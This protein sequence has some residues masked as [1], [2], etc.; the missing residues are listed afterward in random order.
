[1]VSRVSFFFKSAVN[2][3]FIVVLFCP[4]AFAIQSE[5]AIQSEIGQSG[6]SLP[7]FVSLKSD[8]VNVR[9]GPSQHQY[10]IAW[11]YRKQGLPVEIIQEYD[12]WRRIRDS[13]G[14]LGWVNQALLSGK[15]TVMITPWKKS[16]N[17]L[18]TMRGKPADNAEIIAHIESG[19]LCKVRQCNGEW[20]ELETG[21]IHGWLKQDL[22]WGVYPGEKI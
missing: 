3:L 5:Q 2:I 8:R 6:L 11:S 22:L 20:C 10:A 7:R 17:P 16:K 15:R 4:L 1:M 9:V 13:D 14:D 21:R 19:V 12:N 18:Q